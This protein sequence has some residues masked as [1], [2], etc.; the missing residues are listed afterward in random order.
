MDKCIHYISMQIKTKTYPNGLRALSIYMPESLSQTTLVLVGAGSDFETAEEAG[1]SHF[2][3]H[4]CFKGTVKRPTPL[5]V[6][7]SLDALGAQSNAFTDH[8]MTGFYAKTSKEKFAD[9]LDIIADVYLNSTLPEGELEKEKGVIIDEIRMYNDEP[10][11][12]VDFLFDATLFPD[13]PE[14]R[15]VAGTEETVKNITRTKMEEYRRRFYTAPNTVVVVAGGVESD[16]VFSEIEKQFSSAV[17]GEKATIVPPLDRRGERV[18]LVNDATEQAHLIVGVKSFGSEDLD[19]YAGTILSTI[20]GGNMSSRLFQKIREEMGVGY[21][22][23]TSQHLAE[24]YGSFSASA[25]VDAKRAVTVVSAMLSEFK[26]MRELPIENEELHHATEYLAS[27]IALS[28]ESNENIAMWYGFK[29]LFDRSLETHEERIEALRAVTIEDV[30]R[31]ANRVL[32]P[33]T[34]QVAVIGSGIDKEEIR[35]LLL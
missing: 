12:K 28:K 17:S 31:V 27:H 15:I 8:Q 35:A 32:D 20:L 14:G 34:L 4:M 23:Y 11:S 1:I 9:S 33:K 6:A 29:Y 21:Y 13:M 24:K 26:K 3:E 25:G 22:V 2:L 19:R 30:Q 5:S 18:A 10:K 7:R 16:E